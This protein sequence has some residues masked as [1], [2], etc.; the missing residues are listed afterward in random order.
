MT[1]T[2]A[3]V[4]RVVR[5]T[6]NGCRATLMEHGEALTLG[7]PDAR[8]QRLRTVLLCPG[9]AARVAA[10]AVT[11]CSLELARQVDQLQREPERAAPV[12]GA[13]AALLTETLVRSA[14]RRRRLRAV[15]APV[16]LTVPCP[17]CGAVAG[18]PCKTRHSVHSIG[19]HAARRC[20]A[21]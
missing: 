7:E 1:M 19:T 5:A 11:W 16:D 20:N 10:V 4:E 8:G 18:E 13:A 6:C 12:L 3:R 21:N 9:C 2:T 14:V 15:A 17:Y